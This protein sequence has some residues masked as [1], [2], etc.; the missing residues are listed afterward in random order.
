MISK[1]ETLEYLLELKEKDE[2]I[3]KYINILKNM[4]SF[5]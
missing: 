5:I 2:N 3:G 4:S 1:D